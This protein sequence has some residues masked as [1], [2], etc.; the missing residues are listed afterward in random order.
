M[1]MVII[2]LILKG[3]AQKTQILLAV[4]VAALNISVAVAG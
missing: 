4:P 2:I 3:A 1:S